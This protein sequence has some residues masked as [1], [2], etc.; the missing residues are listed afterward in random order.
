MEEE[1]YFVP[2]VIKGTKLEQEWFKDIK[3]LGEFYPQGRM[4]LVNERGTVE[5]FILKCKERLCGCAQLEIT[6]QTCKTLAKYLQNTKE[7][8][9]RVY[10]YLLTV[11]RKAEMPV[12]RLYMS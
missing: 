7:T 9:E 1:K 6:M 11:Y 8:N 12:S 2:P 4:V 3:S 10:N 5:N